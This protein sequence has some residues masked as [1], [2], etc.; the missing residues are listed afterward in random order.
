MYLLSQRVALSLLLILSSLHKCF[1]SPYISQELSSTLGFR[2]SCSRCVAQPWGASGP[3]GEAARSPVTTPANTQ[4]HLG[5]RVV[6]DQE[7]G[8]WDLL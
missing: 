7:E 4:P 3:E 5:V 1:L 2:Q 8:W 6:E